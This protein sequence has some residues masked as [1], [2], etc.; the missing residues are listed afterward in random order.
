MF[1]VLMYVAQ[2]ILRL[3]AILLSHLSGC[4]D[5]RYATSHLSLKNIIL[6]TK[7]WLIYKKIDNLKHLCVCVYRWGGD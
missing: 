5:Y 3:E 1:L 7:T 4:W 6:L 2:A